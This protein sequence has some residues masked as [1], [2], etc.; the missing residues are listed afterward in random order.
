[1]VL[2][3]D[4]IAPAK[5]LEIGLISQVCA[6][7]RLTA[8]ADALTRRILALKPGSARRCKEFFQTVQQNNFDQNCRLAAETL[9]LGSLANLEGG[10]KHGQ[11]ERGS[12]SR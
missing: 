1:M 12:S 10:G 7:D 4:A 2:F 11:G 9:A 5:A 8:D 6:P 3:G